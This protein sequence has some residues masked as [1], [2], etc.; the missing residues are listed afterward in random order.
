MAI[1]AVGCLPPPPPPPTPVTPMDV[2]AT[3]PVA[4][5]QFTFVDTSRGTPAFGAYPGAPSRRIP[6]TVWYPSDGGGPYPLVMFLPGYGVTG[7]NYSSLISRIAA[8]GY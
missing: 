3:H 4:T 2:G 7:A 8:A 5:R 6:T 1:V